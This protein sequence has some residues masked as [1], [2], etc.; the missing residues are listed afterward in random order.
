MDRK[1]LIAGLLLTMLISCSND[2]KDRKEDNKKVKNIILLI[3]DGMG[4]SQIYAGMIGSQKPLELEKFK[5]IGFSKTYSFN[6][7]IT[8]SGAAATAIAIGRKTYNQAIGVDSDTL[9]HKTILEYAEDNGLSTGLV[10]TSGI[11]HATPASFIA[12]QKHRNLYEEI[13]A[14]FLNTD[15]EVIIGGSRNNFN[16]RKDSIDLLFE[17]EKKGYKVLDNIEQLNLI[18]SGKVVC[19]T[20]DNH[21]PSILDG[22]GD[23]LSLATKKA[24]NIL[25][26]NPEGFFLIIEGSQIDWEAHDNNTEGIITEMIDFDKAIGIAHKFAEEDGNTLVIVTADHETGGLT[27]NGGNIEKGKIL[28][29]FST[30]GHSGVMVPVFAF[31][32]GSEEF[33]GIYENTA[34]FDK[35]M[36]MFGFEKESL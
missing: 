14:D 12:H 18:D 23:M 6:A 8:D 13:A 21:P 4:V 35:M 28:G 29:R 16:N 17:F 26:N 33:R 3:G 9:A 32:P 10:S 24:L 19:L 5:N 25:D 27:I 30:T 11:T 31:G 36:K 15:F 20:H 2:K 1:L 34:L 7:F 22:R